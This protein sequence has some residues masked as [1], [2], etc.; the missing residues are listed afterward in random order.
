MG[1]MQGY[2]PSLRFKVDVKTHRAACRVYVSVS[3]NQ[4]RAV[5]QED[6]HLNILE[7]NLNYGPICVC[8]F[9]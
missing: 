8:V 6:R 1:K 3:I 9:V 5:P 7:V 2:N 4:P